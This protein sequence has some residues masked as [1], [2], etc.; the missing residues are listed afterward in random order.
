MPGRRC[1]LE[2]ETAAKQQQPCA[3]AHGKVWFGSQL[4]AELMS[5]A[6]N[7]SCMDRVATTRKQEPGSDTVSG[8]YMQST[9]LLFLIDVSMCG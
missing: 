6:I 5:H 4:D 2:Q 8:C 7:L 1:C 9:A 3:S